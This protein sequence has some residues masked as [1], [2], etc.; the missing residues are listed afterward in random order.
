[1]PKSIRTTCSMVLL[2]PFFILLI[3][4]ITTL[5]QATELSTLLLVSAALLSVLIA[6]L[7]IRA[8][9]TTAIEKLEQSINTQKQLLSK[10]HINKRLD[11]ETVASEFSQLIQNL[12]E[13]ADYYTQPINDIMDVMKEVS[14]NNLTERLTRLYRGDL[15]L[16]ADHVNTAIDRLQINTFLSEKNIRIAQKEKEVTQSISQKQKATLLEIEKIIRAVHKG[17]LSLRIPLQDTTDADR[18]LRNNINNMVCMIEEP[19][20]EIQNVMS[21]VSNKQLRK[22]ITNDYPGI[23]ND[24]KEHVNSAIDNLR[25]TISI[26][27]AAAD[28]VS[29]ATNH[30]AESSQSLAKDSSD[31][32][33]SLGDI[34]QSLITIEGDTK[35]N[36]QSALN[37][38]QLSSDATKNALHGKEIMTQMTTAMEKINNS[39]TKTADIIKT[40]DEIAMQTNLLALNAAVEAARAGEA[41]QGFAVVADEVR[42]LAQRSAEAAKSTTDIISISIEDIKDGVALAKEVAN[43]LET[44]EKSNEEVNSLIVDISSSSQNQSQSILEVNKAV[45]N[46]NKVTEKNAANAEETA[47]TAEEMSSQAQELKA[48]VN[49]FDVESTEPGIAYLETQ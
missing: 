41:G 24:L 15:L 45:T 13:I 2:I 48:L 23:F 17:D 21:D 19:L 20:V 7:Y 46:I 31:Q 26:V 16:M 38:K 6:L 33:Y 22:K 4:L 3:T 18:E 42:N 14:D 40:I 34:S 10:G 30:V 8:S 36:S 12:N 44:I 1:M 29:L 28:Q 49:E 11:S 9:T 35:A 39:S 25:E 32:A 27:S 43:S 5:Q 47:A 37:A